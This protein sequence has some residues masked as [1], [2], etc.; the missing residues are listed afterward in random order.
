MNSKAISMIFLVFFLHCYEG[1]KT[2]QE[3]RQS[4]SDKHDQLIETNNAASPSFRCPAFCNKTNERKPSEKGTPYKF[5]LQVCM[6]CK[7]ERRKR[8]N[9]RCN[10]LC[11]GVPKT[12]FCR[13]C[14]Y[15]YINKK[16]KE[17]I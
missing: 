17:I 13:R 14:R 16:D 11:T 8:Q 2:F 7:R 15:D 5:T 4:T 10:S 1:S 9:S 3:S 6:K 12:E